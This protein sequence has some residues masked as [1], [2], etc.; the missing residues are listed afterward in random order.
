MIYIHFL[1]HIDLVLS[2]NK[3]LAYG[4]ILKAKLFNNNNVITK[5][6]ML[7]MY[8][9]L[10]RKCKIIVLIRQLF[11]GNKNVRL[12]ADKQFGWM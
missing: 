1:S 6:F 7:Y 8:S 9:M 3:F 4:R 2:K 10:D 5:W 12:G 11:F